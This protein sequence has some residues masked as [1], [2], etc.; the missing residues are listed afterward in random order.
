MKKEEKVWRNKLYW[1]FEV[2]WWIA[3]TANLT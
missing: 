1:G 3:M 2:P